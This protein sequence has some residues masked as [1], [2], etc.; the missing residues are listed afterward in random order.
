M[1]VS[2]YKDNTS[3]EEEIVISRRSIT[4][5]NVKSSCDKEFLFCFR[6]HKLLAV[7]LIS[8]PDKQLM[9]PAQ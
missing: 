9:L 5:K 7:L 4:E 1:C 8:P 2:E 3:K 6:L